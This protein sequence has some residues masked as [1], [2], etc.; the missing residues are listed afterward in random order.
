MANKSR[1]S[2]HNV[3]VQKLEISQ[4]ISKLTAFISRL[5]QS[6]IIFSI[7]CHARKK[8]PKINTALPQAF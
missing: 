7:C 5:Q 1:G 8:E 4:S 2:L 3:A 6:L